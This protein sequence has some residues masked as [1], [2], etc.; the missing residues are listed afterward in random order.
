M[1]CISFA[2]SRAVATETGASPLGDSAETALNA[3][4]ANRTPVA[5][6]TVPRQA[7]SLKAMMN[8]LTSLGSPPNRYG[9]TK[10]IYSSILF[11]IKFP[12]VDVKVQFSASSEPGHP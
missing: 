1:L 10:W 9:P 12:K 2:F 5:P 4:R 6:T 7:D 8:L 11:Y 3:W